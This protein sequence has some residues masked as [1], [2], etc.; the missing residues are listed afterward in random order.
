M[1]KL[2][3]DVIDLFKREHQAWV[4]AISEAEAQETGID[5]NLG[6]GFAERVDLLM[7]SFREF[8]VRHKRKGFLRG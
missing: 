5:V 2:E 4:K 6:G 1:D 3:S 7:K 8:R